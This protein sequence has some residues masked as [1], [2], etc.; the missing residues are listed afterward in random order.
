MDAYRSIL[1]HMDA[2]PRCAMRLA[3]ARQLAREHD[4][5]ALLALLALEPVSFP[6]PVPVDLGMPVFRDEVDPEHRRRARET[7]DAALATGD[8]TMTWVEAPPMPPA[9]GMSQASHYVDLVVLGQRDPEDPLTADVPRDF[10]ESVVMASGKPALVIPYAGR[11]DSI[12]RNVL[13][14]WRPTR[15]CARAVEAALPLLQ[16]AARVHVVCW[17]EDSFGPAET[18]F[19]I[20]RALRWHGVECTAHRYPKEPEKL[21]EVLLSTAAAQDSELLVMGAYGHH[22]LRELLLGGTTRTL[23]RSMTLPVLMAH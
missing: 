19:G 9:W 4:A 20:V 2:S 15:E 14:A 17:G 18:T 6:E 5:A 10:V 7:F 11:F 3:L 8:P 12:G 16:R 21:G 22:R 1:V 23:L 13:I